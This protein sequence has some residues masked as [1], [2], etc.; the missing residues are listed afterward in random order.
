MA[1]MRAAAARVESQVRSDWTFVP[2]MK[3]IAIKFE[4]LCGDAA[5]V[6]HNVDKS[7]AGKEHALTLTDALKSLYEKLEGGFSNDGKRRRAIKHDMT[8]LKFADLTTEERNVV[9]DLEFMSSTIPGTQQ[10]RTRIHYGIYSI[11]LRIPPGQERKSVGRY[12]GSWGSFNWILLQIV[13]ISTSAR[14]SDELSPR[15]DFGVIYTLRG[16]PRGETGG[17][18]GGLGSPHAVP[19]TREG[20]LWIDF[21]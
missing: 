11:A 3:N 2:A 8:K 14:N 7:M 18:Q 13:S 10:I 6:R 19:G 5:A 17:L 1:V 4:A 20:V 21:E 9:K 15:C 16:K 12:W